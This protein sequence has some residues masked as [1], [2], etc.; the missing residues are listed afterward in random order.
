MNPCKYREQYERM[1]RWYARFSVIDQG[2]LHDVTSDHYEDDVYAF[3]LNCYH[4]KDWIKNDPAVGVA[5]QQGV[6][7]FINSSRSLK[8]CADICNAHKHLRLTSSRSGEHPGFGKK[9]VSLTL[10][11]GSPPAISV[12][13]EIDTATGPVDAF[14]L[15]TDCVKDW[16]SFIQANCK[17]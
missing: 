5:A 4:L 3:F 6:E 2:R 8:L 13:Y 16:E 12:K 17:C 10:A 9:H 15:A 11:V 7:G 14:T 1:K